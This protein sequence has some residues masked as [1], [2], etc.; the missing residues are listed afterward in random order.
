MMDRE[1][2]GRAL[3]VREDKEGGAGPG[4]KGHKKGNPATAA[5]QV[6]IPSYTNN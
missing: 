2:K 1:L 5:R 3:F 4:S 6:I